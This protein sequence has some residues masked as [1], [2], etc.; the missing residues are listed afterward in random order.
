MA[1]VSIAG[2][3]SGRPVVVGHVGNEALPTYSSMRP[4]ASPA[5]HELE[6][7]I[8]VHVYKYTYIYMYGYVYI[9]I[10]MYMYFDLFLYTYIYIFVNT[11]MCACVCGKRRNAHIFVH[12]SRGFPANHKL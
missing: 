7:C 11:N 10:Y 4:V 3:S 5:K 1:S 9:Y 8:C 2:V 6:V 12:V